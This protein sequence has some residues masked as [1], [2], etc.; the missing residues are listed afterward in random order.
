MGVA[1]RYA[2]FTQVSLS[3][4]GSHLQAKNGQLFSGTCCKGAASWSKMCSSFGSEGIALPEPHPNPYKHEVCAKFWNFH[5]LSSLPLRT[6]LCCHVFQ[7][8]PGIKGRLRP[9]RK[10][11]P[12]SG[13]QRRAAPDRANRK[14]K[15]PARRHSGGKH[16]M[17]VHCMVPWMTTFL[18]SSNL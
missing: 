17:E 15:S 4:H 1:P 14:E 3:F 10:L 12:A 11:P 9:P 16:H 5:E 7:F 2:C 13:S 18:P 8:P 6:A